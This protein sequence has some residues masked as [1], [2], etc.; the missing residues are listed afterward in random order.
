MFKSR[1]QELKVTGTVQR[2]ER[3]VEKMGTV[4]DDREM[5]DSLQHAFTWGSERMPGKF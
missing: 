4:N 3:N 2:A 5:R 1:S